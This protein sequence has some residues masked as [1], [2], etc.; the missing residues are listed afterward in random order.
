VGAQILLWGYIWSS[1]ALTPVQSGKDGYIAMNKLLGTSKQISVAALLASVGPFL[2][3]FVYSWLRQKW[4]AHAVKFNSSS[5]AAGSFFK[6]TT[7]GIVSINKLS[8]FAGQIVNTVVFFAV[9]NFNS[10]TD[11]SVIISIIVSSCVVKCVIAIADIP[12]LIIA[13][14][15]MAAQRQL[16][17][18]SDVVTESVRPIS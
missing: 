10:Q 18:S 14:N 6:S 12:F 8:T 15:L 11:T 7:L 9:S 5:S 4:D 1:L 17:A 16:K 3:I 13:V 2:G